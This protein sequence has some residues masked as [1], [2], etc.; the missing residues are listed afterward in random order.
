MHYFDLLYYGIEQHGLTKLRQGA[1]RSGQPAIQRKV[2]IKKEVEGDQGLNRLAT[3]QYVSLGNGK[4][5]VVKKTLPFPNSRKETVR[6][7]KVIEEA[8]DEDASFCTSK[9]SLL[10]E[11]W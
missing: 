9:S 3:K 4:V 7:G 6:A 10:E 11:W 8:V 1:S 2:T 5:V